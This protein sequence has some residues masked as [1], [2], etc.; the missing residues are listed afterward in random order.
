MS[1]KQK[2]KDEISKVVNGFD[3]VLVEKPKFK[4]HGDAASNIAMVLAKKRGR[5]PIEIANE[6]RERLKTNTKLISNVEV[7][8]PGFLNFT[9]SDELL[10]DLLLEV[11]SKK[12]NYGCIQKDSKEKI[13]LEFVSA[14]PTGDLHIGHGRQ[15]V[16]G[17]SLANLL[18]AAGYE[19]STEFYINDFGEQISNL[20][21]TV[22]AVYR[23][24]K[25]ENPEWKEDFYPEEGI[26]LYVKQIVEQCKSE[27]TP[28]LLGQ[29]VK[30][31]ILK[32][33]QELLD[34]CK[35]EFNKWFSETD[36]H[37]SGSVE[38]ILT[39]LKK[40]NYVYEHEGA[41][42]FKAKEL[43]DVRDRVLIRSDKRPTYLLADIAYHFDKLKRSQ[44]LITIWGADHQGQE[45]SLKGALKVLGFDENSIEI[46][47]VQLVSLKKEGQEVK[48]S[49]RAG[50]VITIKEVIQEVGTDAFRYFLVETHANNRMVFDLDLAKKQDKE[51]PVYYIQYAHARCC[52]IFRQLQEKSD[53]NP[54]ELFNSFSVNE[55]LFTNLFKVSNE[56][57]SITKELILNILDFPEEV[58]NSAISRSPNRIANYLKELANNFHQFYTICRVISDNNSLTKAR[59]GLV[60]ATR[61]TISN[62]L[63]ILG[64][65]APESM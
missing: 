17:S 41:I 28:L 46:I 55:T 5:S 36:L 61:I 43:G 25:G 38:N 33:Q 32:S 8:K 2:I 14:N 4:E 53:F 24:L 22:W 54:S 47:F 49:K 37:K 9:V 10:A 26:A 56:E 15:A 19:V 34:S 63:K 51:N 1:Y 7:A 13:L 59:L 20:T 45:V 39:L 57:Y 29:A 65:T 44:K 27:V 23:K 30:D 64:I 11:H 50:N 60:E 3:Q 18:N 16:I 40:S 52:S 48:M 6:I 12:E 31:L 58:I 62:G 42:W 21:E 35:V